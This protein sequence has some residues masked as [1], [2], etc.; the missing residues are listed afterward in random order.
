MDV[1]SFNYPKVFEA[2][3][4]K[5]EINKPITIKYQTIPIDPSIDLT[6]E[7]RCFT[8]TQFHRQ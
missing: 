2:P 5:T 6:S 7:P 4:R 8:L 3:Y 1:D